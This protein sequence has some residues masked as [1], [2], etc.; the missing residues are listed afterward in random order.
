MYRKGSGDARGRARA[1]A[2]AVPP[3]ASRWPCDTVSRDHGQADDIRRRGR[4]R[5]ARRRP[6]RRRSARASPTATA[7][8]WCCSSPAYFVMARRRRRSVLPP[9]RAWSCSPRRRGSPCAPPRWSAAC[10]A[11]R[12]LIPVATLAA[13]VAQRHSAATTW[14]G[15]VTAA[16][17]ALLVVV[18]P[19][20]I[21]RR[22]ATHPVVNINT[23]YGAICVYLLIAMFFA[24]LFALSGA[25][26]SDSL[27]RADPAARRRPARSTTSTS[28]SRRSRPSGYGD[29]TAR[30]D[31]GRMMAVLEAVLGQLYLITVVALVVQNLGQARRKRKPPT[32]SESAARAARQPLTRRRRPSCARRT[33][34]LVRMPCLTV[35]LALA[36]SL[37]QEQRQR[38]DDGGRRRAPA[39]A[40]RSRRPR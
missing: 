21:V 5:V 35:Q 14:P 8:C 28:A 20:A 15:D 11:G 31:V 38:G 7:S 24:S 27:L 4:R 9:G 6:G 34:G 23:F 18:A 40:G 16:L 2:S 3:C 10:C 12:A 29:L 33:R 37:P 26:S 22:L 36:R 30:G 19:A 17:A 13:I 39:P 1:R 25:L 32:S